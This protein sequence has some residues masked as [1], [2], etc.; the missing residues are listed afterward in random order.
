VTGATAD[1][2]RQGDH[3]PARDH[4]RRQGDL[5]VPRLRRHGSRQGSVPKCH[6]GHGRVETRTTNAIRE[7]RV[8][9]ATGKLTFALANGQSARLSE[10]DRSAQSPTT[11][12]STSA[13]W[14]V[15]AFTKIYISA[16]ADAKDAATAVQKALDDSKLFTHASAH[17]DEQKKEYVALVEGVNGTPTFGDVGSAVE[18]AGTGYKLADMAWSAPCEACAKN[19]L[20]QAG[21]KNCW[22]SEAA[23]G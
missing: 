12:R 17:Y 6:E 11:S 7:A 9:P 8:D 15:T 22:G 5:E 4:A 23:H 16:P 2:R 14:P 1:N 20:T 21:C 18:K 3:R 13:K 19:G 10:L